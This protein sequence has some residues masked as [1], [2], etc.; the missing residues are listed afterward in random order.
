MQT[1][2]VSKKI[3]WWF[4]PIGCNYASPRK[5][6]QWYKENRPDSVNN[7]SPVALVGIASTILGFLIGGIGAFKD[8]KTNTWAGLVFG[9]SGLLL[10]VA[11]KIFAQKVLDKEKTDDPSTIS[12]VLSNTP[13][14]KTSIKKPIERS[15]PDTALTKNAV[16]TVSDIVTLLDQS[17]SIENVKGLLNKLSPED[18]D[19]LIRIFPEFIFTDKYKDS[20]E[21][22]RFVEEL[23]NEEKKK[24]S[25]NTL[26]QFLADDNKYTRLWALTVLLELGKTD[27]ITNLITFY[28]D[29]HS[30]RQKVMET[31]IFCTKLPIDKYKDLPCKAYKIIRSLPQISNRLYLDTIRALSRIPDHIK[32]EK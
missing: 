7:S 11:G 32:S 23:L 6:Y 20:S 15:E 1:T 26:I 14:R 27:I 16:H 17:T 2:S 29:D 22:V 5:I 10:T 21:V 18:R 28:I 4:I 3:N 13:K 12:L 24:I 30:N 19:K 25:D 9:A 31:L 8:S